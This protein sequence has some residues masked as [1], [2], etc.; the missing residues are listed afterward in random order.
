[1]STVTQPNPL[2]EGLHDYRVARPLDHGHL[3]RHRR[4]ERRKLLPALYNLA[5]QRLL[6]AGFAVVG[7]AIDDLDDDAFRKHAV[8]R[9]SR[10]FSRTQP[11]DQH[12]A[13]GLPRR[14]CSTC[15]VDFSKLEDFKALERKARASSTAPATPAATAS[16]TARRRRR[17]TRRSSSS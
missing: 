13:A 5:K 7:A 9:R 2:A 8:G 1:M 10:K 14:R 17:P 4:P 11:I 15:K 12:G 6:P 16:T 3:R